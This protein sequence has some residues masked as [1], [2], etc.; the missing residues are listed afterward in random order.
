MAG[1]VAFTSAG[2]AYGNPVGPDVS[3]WQHIDGRGIDW[4]AVKHS[5]HQFAMVKATEGLNYFN[6]F[7]IEDC[8]VMRA[9]GVARGA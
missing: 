4:F 8:I 2:V 6:P 1:A 7:F 9:A 5:G 3:S